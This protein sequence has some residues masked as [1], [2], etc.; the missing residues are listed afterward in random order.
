MAKA[1]RNWLGSSLGASRYSRIM[2]MDRDK[3]LNQR[4]VTSFLLPADALSGAPDIDHLGT[5]DE[6]LFRTF[7]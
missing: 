7:C 2:F 5:A 3:I 6:A 4:V 1:A